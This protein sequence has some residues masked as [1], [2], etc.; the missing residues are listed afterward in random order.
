MGKSSPTL[1]LTLGQAKSDGLICRDVKFTTVNDIEKEQCRLIV[2]TW[3]DYSIKYV[4]TAIRP[5]PCKDDA[6]KEL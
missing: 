1:P 6:P 3:E 5:N 2:I 4:A